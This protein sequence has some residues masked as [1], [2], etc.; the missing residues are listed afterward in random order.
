MQV[1]KK[2]TIVI[3]IDDKELK[4]LQ[5]DIRSVASDLDDGIRNGSPIKDVAEAVIQGTAGPFHDLLMAILTA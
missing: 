2:T 3:T 5:S 1:T 4:D